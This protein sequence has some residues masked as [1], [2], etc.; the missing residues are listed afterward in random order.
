MGPTSY[1]SPTSAA[2]TWNTI[3]P[4]LLKESTYN[5]PFYTFS[6]GTGIISNRAAAIST[7]TSDVDPNAV[8]GS[9]RNGRYVSPAEW[10]KVLLLPKK[11]TSV[12]TTAAGTTLS[13]SPSSSNP[14]D[15]TPSTDFI[16]PD[17]ILTAVDGSN[18]GNAGSGATPLDFTNNKTTS[19]NNPQSPKFVVGRYAYTIYNEGGL[20]DANVAGS[21]GAYGPTYNPAGNLSTSA[22]STGGPSQQTIWSHKG[23]VAFADLTV[24][25]GIANVSSITPQQVSDDLVGWR[26]A[27]TAQPSRSLPSYTFNNS[28][29]TNYFSYILGLSSRFMSAGSLT[30]GATS[31]S[32]FTSR[33]QLI[34]FLQD[35]STNTTDQAYLQD[36]MMYL[37]TFSRSLNQPSYWPDPNRPMELG[38]PPSGNLTNLNYTGLNSLSNNEPTYNPPFRSIRVAAPGFIRPAGAANNDPTLNPDGAT[39]VVGEPLVKKRFPL[40]RLC[41]ITA[42]GPSANIVGDPIYN[43]FLADGIPD[44]LLKEG[45]AANILAYFDLQ[46]SGGTSVG[47]SWTYD[48]NGA[49]NSGSNLLIPSLS[50]VA[51]LNREPNFFELLQA[52]IKVG[53]LGRASTV[54]GAASNSTYNLLKDT[55]VSAHIIQIG[56]NIIDETNPTQ[57]P[58][59]IIFN[60]Q[61]QKTDVFG[62]MDLPYLYGYRNIGYITSDDASITS[63]TPSTKPTPTP[64]LKGKLGALCVPIIWNPYDVNGPAPMTGE[65][66][67]G[68]QLVAST[69]TTNPVNSGSWSFQPQYYSPTTKVTW[70]DPTYK[71]TPLSWTNEILTFNNNLLLYREPTVLM[72]PNLPSGSNLAYTAGSDPSESDYLDVD[73]TPLIGFPLGNGFPQQ[74]GYTDTSTNPA[75]VYVTVTT[76]QLG[77]AKNTSPPPITFKLQYKSPTGTIITYQQ[78]AVNGA[79]SSIAV[80]FEESPAAGYPYV[81]HPAPSGNSVPL[82]DN[83]T[84]SSGGYWPTRAL[85]DPR[86][87]RFGST[88]DIWTTGAD[89]LFDLDDASQDMY[90]QSLEP[91]NLV[92]DGD[93]VNSSGKQLDNFWYAGAPVIFNSRFGELSQNLNQAIQYHYSDADSVF[94][95]AMGGELSTSSTASGY[96]NATGPT[97]TYATIGLPLASTVTISAPPFSNANPPTEVPNSGFSPPSGQSE[98]RPL[99]LHRPFRS[100]AELGYVFS[101]TPWKNLSFSDPESGFNVLLDTFC[102]NEDYQPDPV[103]AGRVD[104]N[105]KQAPVFQAVLSGAYRD[106]NLAEAATL[107]PSN[108]PT[109]TGTPLITSEAAAIAHALVARTSVAPIAVPAPFPQTPVATPQPFANVADLVGRYTAGI[110]NPAANGNAYDGFSAD[111]AGIYSVSPNFSNYIQRYRDTT[112]RA[113]SDSGQAG[114]WDLLIDVIAQTGHYPINATNAAD[115]L[116]EGQR[117]YWVHVAIDRQTGQVI[118][119]NIEVVNE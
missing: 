42:K 10:N 36:A 24:L 81:L 27:A 93:N 72:E 116:V 77:I 105:S 53:A 62:A 54:Y 68:L 117:H 23:P 34:S 111:L 69:S 7:S 18:P 20:L 75:T 101:G 82:W 107:S 100:V 65:I 25:P 58:T 92:G 5:V 15:T 60:Y 67:S 12:T 37:G 89:P 99:L 64:S 88:N 21:P 38:R 79:T 48:P 39:A 63:V 11:G 17:W 35:L 73:S 13:D 80:P 57:F 19:N 115:F 44:H 30:G 16:A 97:G 108:L 52:A 84:W 29:I 56:A 32:I 94:R 31:D 41:W 103:E 8:S 28:G 86:T 85:Y 6:N 3:F 96:G 113:L 118:D 78:Y 26:N 50:A 61:G 102:I 47:G 76:D 59:H 49:E 95:R 33:Q 90:V 2:S 55:N 1:G 98:S 9:S 87:L 91:T 104:L 74:W 66:P 110:A 83:T 106:E 70:T 22:S 45:T 109:L 14:L 51:A 40:N 119:K 46:W 112:M 4:N 43:Q 71:P 114:T